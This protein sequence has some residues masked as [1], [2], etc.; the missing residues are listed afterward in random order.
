MVSTE[1]ICTSNKHYIDL[2]GPMYLKFYMCVH[3]HALTHTSTNMY[4][5]TYIHATKTIEKR[6]QKYE[7]GKGVNRRFEKRKRKGEM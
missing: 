1:N 3:K 5:C 2:V 6:D 7:K 4:A